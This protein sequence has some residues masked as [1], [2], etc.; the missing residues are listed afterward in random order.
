M[1]SLH[2]LAQAALPGV[3]DPSLLDQAARAG[4]AERGGYLPARFSGNIPI[5]PPETRPILPESAANLLKRMLTGEH[6]DLLPELL[7]RAAAGGFV[8]PPETLPAM[9]E[10]KETA[11]RSLLL[12]VLGERGRW[13][14]AQN[15]AWDWALPR[16]PRQAWETG[17]RAQR[18]AA[19]KTIRAERPAEARAWMQEEWQRDS[20][21]E[22]ATFLS[23]FAI[24][25][26]PDDEPFLEA[27]LDDRRK[28]VREAAQM[29]LLRLPRSR[30]MERMW[31]RAQP[32]VRA[33]P[34]LQ[35]TLP[36]EA[37]SAARRDGLDDAPLR[38]WMGAGANRLARL[39]ACVP[40]SRWSQ[41]LRRS[42]G[43][44]LS[45]AM[46]SEWRE[47][48]LVGWALAACRTQDAD[49]AAAVLQQAAASVNLRNL[50]EAETLQSL[51]MLL[52]PERMQAIVETAFAQRVQDDASPLW[53]IL[54]QYARPWTPALAWRVIQEMQRQAHEPRSRLPHLLPFFAR[55]I[56]P[57]M[58]AEL[59]AGWPE[60][61]S[62]LWQTK[63]DEFLQILSFRN[64]IWHSLENTP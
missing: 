32:L 2:A 16:E 33:D 61:T 35:V 3:N 30:L 62:A 56:P 47:P 58:S 11:L 63:I 45:L 52:A 26:S 7:E 43:A 22:R 41:A 15:P 10:T 12:P 40:P 1:T 6:Q 23:A 31:A 8:L 59:S 20:P 36:E 60:H 37:D 29:L 55:R 38:K 51:A 53:E 46:E 50:L 48:L 9:L 13:L 27:C 4:L 21:E 24:G 44:L 17:T 39:L 25:L 54:Q 34:T 5:C 18:L 19:L 64:R 49:W 28:E 57:E 14:A 42:P